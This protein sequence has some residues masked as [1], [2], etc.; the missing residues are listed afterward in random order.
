M[1]VWCMFFESAMLYVCCVSY[2][3]CFVYTMKFY[4][5]V[6]LYVCMCMFM[7]DVC[8]GVSIK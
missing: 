7:L 4:E 1:R 3:V 6:H 5:F 8:P 2:H